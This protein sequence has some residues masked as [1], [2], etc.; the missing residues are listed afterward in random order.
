MF[1]KRI[2]RQ[3]DYLKRER[4]RLREK[5]SGYEEIITIYE[6]LVLYLAEH[7]AKNM[8]KRGEKAFEERMRKLICLLRDKEA[9]NEKVG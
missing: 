6:S 4:V 5:I 3:N 2:K 7:S 8:P 1:N 9:E